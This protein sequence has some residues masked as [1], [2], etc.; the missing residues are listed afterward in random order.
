MKILA[1]AALLILAVWPAA[2]AG[3]V[4]VLPIP[5][6]TAGTGTTVGWGFSITNDSDWLEVTSANFCL[7]SSGTETLCLPP[8]LGVFT[9]FISGFND[10]IVGP[11][12]DS[13]VVAQPFSDGAHTGIGSFLITASSG[14]PDIGQIVLT[15]NLFSRSPNDPDFNPDTDVLSNDNFLTASASVSLSSGEVPACS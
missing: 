11:F 1:R 15:Y 6:L 14:G 5:G 12:P 13:V 8:T 2:H 3:P 9:D 4:L 7:G 10:I